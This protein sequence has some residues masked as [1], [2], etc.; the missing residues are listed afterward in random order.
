M[1]RLPRGITFASW[2]QA[3]E[4]AVRLAGE[5][6]QADGT[7]QLIV[8]DEFPY[9][10]SDSPEL[11]GVIQALYDEYGPTRGRTSP[12]VRLVLCGSALSVM[13]DLLTERKALYGR[14]QVDM[15]LTAFDYRDTATFWG[16]R[17]AETAF[18][19][20]AVVGGV[21]GYKELT[22]SAGVPQTIDEFE[23]WVQ[24]TVLNPAHALFD[25]TDLLFSQ[26]PGICDRAMYFGVLA[27]IAVGEAVPRR[28]PHV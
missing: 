24:G 20:H 7:P 18:R 5:R 12:P 19:L 26:E 15:C 1:G 28:S 23:Q 6:A 11:P 17:D 27:A 4:T 2:E 13:S 21:P 3:L 16:I 22:A 14:A 25:E 9:L 10:V 8:L